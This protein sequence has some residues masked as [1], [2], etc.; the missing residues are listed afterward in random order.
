MVQLQSVSLLF[1]IILVW[2][3]FIPS[4]CVQSQNKVNAEGSC[5]AKTCFPISQHLHCIWTSQ[6]SRLWFTS[7]AKV[8]CALSIDSN[9]KWAGT[10]RSATNTH[11]HTKLSNTLNSTTHVHI[12]CMTNV[13]PT[14]SWLLYS[15]SGDR[16]EF[17]MVHLVEINFF[18]G[19]YL[20]Q[21]FHTHLEADFD[22]MHTL[23]HPM[24]IEAC[25]WYTIAQRKR[26]LK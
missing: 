14:S 5:K 8:Q 26:R 2:G 22:E 18:R 10:K 15:I 24:W 9:S 20:V 4:F 12:Q 23:M 3:I 1:C 13:P 11:S 7:P 25:Y 16:L 6:P 17:G 21:F 19:G